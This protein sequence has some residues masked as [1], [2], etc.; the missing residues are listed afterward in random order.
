MSPGEEECFSWALS[1]L[2]YGPRTSSET[3]KRLIKRG[4]SRVTADSVVS[5]LCES[6]L[7]DDER[8]AADY[9]EE[10]LRKGMGARAVRAKLVA[11]GLDR[12]LVDSVMDMYPTELDGERALQAARKKFRAVED[13]CEADMRRISDFLIRRGFPASTARRVVRVISK[14]D[15]DFDPE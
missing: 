6:G 12:Q 13:P 2:A 10:M 4:C 15:S 14:V 3:R 9:L 1:F 8:F 7:I 5:R 11:K